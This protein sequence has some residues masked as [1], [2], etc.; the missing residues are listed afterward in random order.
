MSTQEEDVEDATMQN[1]RLP[2]AR[3]DPNVW[4]V[5]VANGTEQ[6]VSEESMCQQA[7]PAVC[8]YMQKLIFLPTD[9]HT[10]ML[11]FPLCLEIW[12]TYIFNT[13]INSIF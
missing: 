2:D 4:C 6:S 13:D 10:F 1:S 11:I 12:N 9:M 5:K 7:H 3:K 8:M